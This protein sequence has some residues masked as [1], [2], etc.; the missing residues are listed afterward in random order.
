MGVESESE[1]Y[2]EGG[3]ADKEWVMLVGFEAAAPGGL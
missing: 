1:G 3:E 2:K